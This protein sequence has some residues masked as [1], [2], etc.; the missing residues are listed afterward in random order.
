MNGHA[1]SR[2]PIVA[3]GTLLLAACSDDPLTVDLPSNGDRASEEPPMAV[4]HPHDSASQ[5]AVTRDPFRTRLSVDFSVGGRLVPGS[6]ITIWVDAVANEDITSGT[7][8]VVLPTRAAMTHAGPGKRP[9]YPEGEKMPVTAQWTLPAMSAGDE[10]RR[11]VNIGSHEKGYYHIVTE[12]STQGPGNSPYVMNE[13]YHQTWMYVTDGG[14]VLT[15]TFDETLFPETIAPQPGPFSAKLSATAAAANQDQTAA[16]GVYAF[17]GSGNVYLRV[18]Y[19]N[20][21]GYQPAAG[22]KL[23]AQYWENGSWGAV[24]MRIVPSDGIISVRCPSGDDDYLEGKVTV[25]QNSQVEGGYRMISFWQVDNSDCG[26]Q[27]Q[28]PGYRHIYLP[29][30]HLNDVVPVLESH[31]TFYRGMVKWVSD[32]G[33]DGSSYNR[34]TDKITF[35][36]TYGSKWTV[37]HEATHAIHNKAMNGTWYASNC[38]DHEID[39]ESSYKCALKEGLADYGGDLGAYGHTYRWERDYPVSGNPKGK[40][41]GNVAAFI[42][43]LIDSTND[44]DDTISYPRSFVFGT[45]KVCRTPNAKRD[46]TA[47]FAWCLE[48]RVVESVHNNHFP[49][50]SAPSGVVGLGNTPNGWDADDVRAVWIQNVG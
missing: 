34:V 35:G 22:A 19:Y 33:D 16:D 11:S 6:A 4:R 39:R 40:I 20:N 44:G 8:K 41:E 50:L 49:G 38:G 13:S 2:V 5:S 47:D 24:V 31:F 14:G 28:L 30:K 9:E 21:G 45:L 32:P 48:K 15:K 27:V 23:S 3:V 17:S 1:M 29:W 12:V 46:D 25:P 18:V 26:T 36:D 42:R 7:V 43:D 37:A 10:W